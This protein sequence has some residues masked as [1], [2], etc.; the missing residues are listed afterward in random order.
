VTPSGTTKSKTNGN[1]ICRGPF[2]FAA[3]SP[4][5]PL[6]HIHSGRAAEKVSIAFRD[7]L[8]LSSHAVGARTIPAIAAETLARTGHDGKAFPT[9]HNADL[10]ESIDNVITRLTGK[11]GQSIEDGFYLAKVKGQSLSLPTGSGTE[12]NG[13]CGGISV[14]RDRARPD[15]GAMLPAKPGHTTRSVDTAGVMYGAAVADKDGK[16]AVTSDKARAVSESG[17]KPVTVLPG[18]P[19]IAVQTYIRGTVPTNLNSGDAMDKV[20]ARA[21]DEWEGFTRQSDREP[22]RRRPA[23]FASGRV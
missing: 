20:V 18:S 15:G 17:R 21:N 4:A 7:H 22:N 3:A 2:G 19:E 10:L 23:G 5:L 1:I 12:Y 16:I 11:Y 8:V 14:P 9:D 13:P 6:V